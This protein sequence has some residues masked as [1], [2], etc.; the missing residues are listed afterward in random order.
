MVSLKIVPSLAKMRSEAMSWPFGSVRLWRR[1][2]LKKCH[3]RIYLSRYG[4]DAKSNDK[5][6]ED[7]GES[8]SWP[9]K[10]AKMLEAMA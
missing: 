2:Y 6:K 1:C 10:V 3:C 5:A 4:K 8:M 9:K 7:G